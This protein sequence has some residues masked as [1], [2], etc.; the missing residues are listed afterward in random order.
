MLDII[1]SSLTQFL[2]PSHCPSCNAYTQKNGQWCPSCLEEIIRNDNLAYGANIRENISPIIS[3][4]KYDKGLKHLIHELKYNNKFY[5]LAFFPALF[6]K[7]DEDWDFSS[8][9]MF[10]P[11]PLYAAKLKKR[12][13]NQVEKIFL[14]WIKQHNFNYCDVLIR[15]KNTKSQFTLQAE[16][17]QENLAD[18]FALKDNI[19]IKGCKCLLLDDI[20]TTGSTLNNCAITLKKHGA[21]SV[22]GLVLASQSNLKN[23]IR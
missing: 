10:I 15:T 5:S 19:N 14:P 12:G 2:F 1:Y 17:R 22:S 16:E 23:S 20:F 8:Y 18:A 13:F 6:A 11:V 7:L 4:G 21:K 9:D 3:I